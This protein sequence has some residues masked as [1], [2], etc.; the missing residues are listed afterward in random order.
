MLGLIGLVLVLEAA[1]RSIGWIVP[2]LALAFVAHTLYC[3]YSLRNGWPVLPDWLFPHAGQNPRDVVSTTFLQSLGVFGPAASVMFRYVFL[4]V[5]F[6]AFLEMSGAT[7]FIMRFAE[8]AFGTKP[9]GPAKVAVISSGLLGSLSGSAVA[10][11]VTTGA[12][13]IPMMRSNGFKRHIAA[14]VRGRRRLG[15][16]AGSSGHGRRRVHDARDRRTAG[17]LPADRAGGLCFPRCSS[18]CRSS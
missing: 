9:G 7:Q 3:F 11:A 6:G 14:A 12:F 1:R 2:A 13:T 8:R 5:V 16:R 15:R 4:F 17:D 10:N 18:T